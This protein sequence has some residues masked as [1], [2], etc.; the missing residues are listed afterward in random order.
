MRVS[1]DPIIDGLT[2][3]IIG[4]AM[5]VSNGLGHGFLEVV[6]KNALAIELESRS[7]SVRKEHS[8]PVRYRETQSLFD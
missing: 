1:V 4:A 2:E 7:L 8:F 5:A 3:R 6:Y